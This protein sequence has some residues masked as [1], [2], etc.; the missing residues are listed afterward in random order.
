MHHSEE[1]AREKEEG[2][3]SVAPIVTIAVVWGCVCQVNGPKAMVAAQ[4]KAGEGGHCV[5]K[6]TR[7]GSVLITFNRCGRYSKRSVLPAGIGRSDSDGK[8]VRVVDVNLRMVSFLLIVICDI[9]T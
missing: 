1:K 2:E 9:I 5:S 8:G 4:A 6:R 7:P 3:K